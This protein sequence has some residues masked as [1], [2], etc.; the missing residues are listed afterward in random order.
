MST[1]EMLS[2]RTAIQA[3]LTFENRLRGG[4]AGFFAIAGL[5]LLNSIIML[6]GAN[7]DFAIGLAITQVV[8]GAAMGFSDHLSGSAL[9][10]LKIVEVLLNLG[11]VAMFAAFGWLVR[12]D[13]AWAFIVGM[14]IYA[15]D[16]LIFVLAGFWLGVALHVFVLF[17]LFQ[18][19]QALYALRDIPTA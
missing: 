6:F 17:V 2:E 5:S 15:V 13:H 11:I 8:E 7:F 14:G 12:R 16:T 19:L 18:G 1:P 3:Q 4:S 9:A 10:L